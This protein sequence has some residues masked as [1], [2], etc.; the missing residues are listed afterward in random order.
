MSA[1]SRILLVP[2]ALALFKYAEIAGIS[3]P[4][5][6]SSLEGGGKDALFDVTSS[7][8]VASASGIC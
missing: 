6:T 1:G 4:I 2:C 5:S 8:I 7:I 3:D